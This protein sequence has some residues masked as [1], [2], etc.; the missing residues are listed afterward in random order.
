MSMLARDDVAVDDVEVIFL[1]WCC[2]FRDVNIDYIVVVSVVN[3][4]VDVDDNF[5]CCD[6]HI[7]RAIVVYCWCC[8]DVVVEIYTEA[9]STLSVL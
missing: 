2:C 3:V 1:S 5:I 6:I 8:S 7:V 4:G 9:L